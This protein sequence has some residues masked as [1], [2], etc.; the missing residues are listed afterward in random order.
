LVQDVLGRAEI[1][2]QPI[3]ALVGLGNRVE[4][5]VHHDG[6]DSA[7]DV[8]AAV[9]DTERLVQQPSRLLVCV[10]RIEQDWIDLVLT[11]GFAERD[12]QVLLRAPEVL[13]TEFHDLGYAFKRSLQLE[14]A[15]ELDLR[16]SKSHAFHPTR[17]TLLR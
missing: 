2:D 1:G 10:R 14:L 7:V 12:Y 8:D 13:R 16:R 5:E 3:F 17:R 9:C 6:S 4:I 11:K 15:I